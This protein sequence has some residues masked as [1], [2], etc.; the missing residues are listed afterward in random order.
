MSPTSLGLCLDPGLHS[1]QHSTWTG[2]PG[3]A[4]PVLHACPSWPRGAAVGSTWD[5]GQTPRQS[6][7][8][9]WLRPGSLAVLYMAG[10]EAA[11][12]WD[13][14]GSHREHARM[15]GGVR[16]EPRRGQDTPLPDTEVRS[17]WPRF[18]LSLCGQV[19]APCA[20]GGLGLRCWSRSRDPASVS[21]GSG[22]QPPPIWCS[23]RA[24]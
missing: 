17:A 5:L 3:K 18:P 13:W 23:H 1:V 7:V 2:G 9:P 12:L 10:R 4:E 11:T 16:E 21:G 8:A 19:P 6:P 24:G 22:A 15:G 14:L 20:S